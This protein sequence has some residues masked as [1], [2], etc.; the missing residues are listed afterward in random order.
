ML[1]GHNM[2]MNWAKKLG[3]DFSYLANHSMIGTDFDSLTGQYATQGPNLYMLARLHARPEMAVDDVLD[4]Y[5]SAF[6]KAKDEVIA[7]FD[8]W[9]QVCDAVTKRPEGLHWASFYR[10]AHHVFTPS[11]MDQ[12]QLLLEK[13]ESAASGDEMAVR[14][15]SYLQKGLRNAQLTLAAQA[16]YQ[17]YRDGKGLQKYRAAIQELDEYRQSVETDLI[18]NMAYLSWAESRTWDRQLLQTTKVP[19]QKLPDPWKFQWD[20]KKQ[21]VEKE[22]FADSVDTSQWLEISTDGPWEKQLVSKRWREEHGKDYTGYAWY[23]TTFEL[24]FDAARPIVKLVFGAVDE[25]CVIWV[26]GKKMLQRSSPSK[27]DSDNSL[28]AFD[29]DI[30]KVVRYD[31]LNS[32]AVR[33]E[34]STGHGG[35]RRPVWLISEAPFHPNEQSVV[36]NGGFERQ[37]VAWGK[38]R[39]CGQFVFE[40]DKNNPHSGK[41]CAKLQCK[42]L[43]DADSQEKY[44]TGA[45]GRWFQSVSVD[46]SKT[47]TMRMCVKTNIAFA[48]NVGIWITGDA[49]RKTIVTEVLN[50]EGLWYEVVV[51]GIVPH[52][53]KVGIY[54]N[55]KDGIGTAWFDD[56]ELFPEGVAKRKVLIV[57]PQSQK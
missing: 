25:A 5:Y 34:S 41:V 11:A 55:V 4:E 54:L 30:S 52:G 39:M 9:Q 47:Y 51:N 10:Q 32:L 43:G 1:D 22:W 31:Q 29:L 45:W 12:G 23:R 21:G 7:Y 40:L 2:P 6:G 24:E 56:V 3:D 15:V 46:R 49:K 38:S 42:K 28:K 20:P 36:K 44:N 8:H 48:G 50:T 33:V 27:G 53:D 57:D 26:N 19:G 13:A 35:I 14:R 16:A 18:C 37:P 17:G